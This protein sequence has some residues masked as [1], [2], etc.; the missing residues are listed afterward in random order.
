MCLSV[1]E[2]ISGTAVAIGTKFCVQIPRG[3]GSV[4]LLWR[5]AMLCTSGFMDDVT[6][7][8]NGPCVH[9]LRLVK[10]SALRGFARPG[11][12]LMSMN[13]LYCVL[14]LLYMHCAV[15]SCYLV[16]W[17]QDWHKAFIDRL[18]PGIASSQ[19]RQKTEP[20]PQGICTTNFVKIGP[21]VPEICSR[22]DRQ[23]RW[24]Q[25]SS[26]LPGQS[27]KGLLVTTTFLPADPDADP[28]PLIWKMVSSD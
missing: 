21:A 22:T 19:R 12:S 23:T 27:N 17:S 8:R 16:L 18:R 26:P 10:Y 6:F 1:R 13:A 20:R 14:F 24:S 7:G 9:A 25:Y 2:H 28:P 11:R 5:C 3:R 15:F 4:L